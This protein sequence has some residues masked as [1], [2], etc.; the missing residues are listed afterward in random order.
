M[1]PEAGCDLN[2]T[3]TQLPMPHQE[4]LIR[5]PNTTPTSLASI[6]VGDSFM[7]CLSHAM[8][9]TVDGNDRKLMYRSYQN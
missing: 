5:F 8:K 6:S 7:V 1:M 2:A 4:W 9:I 3:N